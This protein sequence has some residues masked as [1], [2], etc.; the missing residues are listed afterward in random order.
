MKITTWNVAGLRALIRKNG[1]A[2]L[3]EYDPDVICLQ[4]IKANLDQIPEKDRWLFTPYETFW[5]PAD[6]KGY[7]GTLTLVKDQPVSLKKG[8]NIDRFDHEGRTIQA[9]FDSFTLFNLY[10]PNGGR[11]HTRVPFKLDFYAALLELCDSMHAKGKNIIICGDINTA[12]QEID[13][14]NPKSKSKITGFLPEE[15]DW[16]SR[17]LSH[18]FVDI[19]RKLYPE[20]VQYTYW[21]YIGN[22]RAKNNGWRLDY[23]LVS[24][25]LLPMV[26][27]VVTHPEI[28]G[29]DHCPVT[30]ILE[31]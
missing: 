9:E 15:R 7:S 17:F 16:I 26:K 18:G 3:N 24:E 13:V 20:R 6:R 4:E 22:Q 28:L 29:S 2:W 12:H 5:N 11:D 23:F 25:R 8:L 14:N 30:L 1:W 27:D 31:M 19:F 10:V 21:S